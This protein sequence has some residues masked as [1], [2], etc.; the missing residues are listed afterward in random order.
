MTTPES[1]RNTW[2]QRKV[3]LDDQRWKQVR[4]KLAQDE[5]NWQGVVELLVQGWLS[6]DVLLSDVRAH[7]KER[8]LLLPE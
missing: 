8:G 2:P 1:P 4:I 5:E 7:L 3:R 6:G